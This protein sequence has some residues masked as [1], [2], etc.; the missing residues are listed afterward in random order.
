[1]KKI[2]I[3]MLLASIFSIQGYTEEHS[4]LY[5]N[6]LHDLYELETAE[7]SAQ[8]E[9]YKYATAEGVMFEMI[10]VHDMVGLRLISKHYLWDANRTIN[11]ADY[12]V[13]Y[14]NLEELK[15]LLNDAFYIEFIQEEP[16]NLKY[17][18]ETLNEKMKT[19]KDKVYI[20]M[21]KLLDDFMV[22]YPKT[23]F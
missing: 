23:V 4:E 15:F 14:G 3:F 19:S 22:K 16:N 7:Q 18:Y 2:I 5:D 13:Y 21:K 17:A 1:M 11:L 6:F 20:E 10:R 8:V 12:A 9:R